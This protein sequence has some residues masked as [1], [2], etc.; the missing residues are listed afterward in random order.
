MRRIAGDNL[1]RHQPIKQHANA[2][3]MLLNGRRGILELHLLDIAGHMHGCTSR[4]SWIRD[5]R[6]N[7]GSLRLRARRRR[8]CWDCDV[9]SKEFEQA[10]DC[11][12]SRPF[13]QRRERGASCK[14]CN[15]IGHIRIRLPFLVSC[16]QDQGSPYPTHPDSESIAPSSG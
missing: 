5:P 13:D 3:Q 6:T 2:S 1:A 14:G 7:A 11:W 9:Y 16:P 12:R 4:S 10:K 8:A 15:F